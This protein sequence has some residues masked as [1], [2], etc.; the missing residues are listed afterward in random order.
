MSGMLKLSGSLFYQFHPCL[1]QPCHCCFRNPAY[2]LLRFED[3]WSNYHG[4]GH[5]SV[6]K[7]L[8]II[9]CVSIRAYSCVPST[10]HA[11][12]RQN[13]ELVC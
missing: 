13:V 2:F 12:Q 9:L 6:S 7:F 5:T 8:Q 4:V 11:M 3:G 1:S 10:F